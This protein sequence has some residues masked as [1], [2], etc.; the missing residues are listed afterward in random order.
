MPAIKGARDEVQRLRRELD[1]L[2]PPVTIEE[3]KHRARLERQMLALEK[4][5]REYD[6]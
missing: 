1:Q 2:G 5:I 4:A 3:A 6:A